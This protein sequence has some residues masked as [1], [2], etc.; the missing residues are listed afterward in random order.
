MEMTSLTVSLLKKE[1]SQFNEDIISSKLK[2]LDNLMLYLPMW[3]SKLPSG[4]KRSCIINTIIPFCVCLGIIGDIVYNILIDNTF[5]SEYSL[6]SRLFWGILIFLIHISRCISLYYFYSRFNWPWYHQIFSYSIKLNKT[7]I[8]NIT[9][10]ITIIKVIVTLSVIFDIISFALWTITGHLEAEFEYLGFAIFILYPQL[11]LVIAQSAIILKYYA[12]LSQ[13]CVDMGDKEVNIKSIVDEYHILYG[14]YKRDYCMSLQI[15]VI[16]VLVAEILY[17][18]NKLWFDQGL[19]IDVSGVVSQIFAGGRAIVV[20]VL[21]FASG[22]LI[23]ECHQK[24]IKKLW[25]KGATFMTNDEENLNKK[26]SFNYGLQYIQKNPI[27][28]KIAGY[29]VTKVNAI[30]LGVL[31]ALT[32]GISMVLSIELLH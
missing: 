15:P 4:K 9:K 17:A 19:D 32:K 12:I 23:T 31:F 30:K 25:E 5:S 28:V 1:T 21:F 8:N 16:L 7:T 14:H 29:P 10:Q 3:I 2:W 24:L 20:V 22:S 6:I 11:F 26:I 13:M 27:D 18:W